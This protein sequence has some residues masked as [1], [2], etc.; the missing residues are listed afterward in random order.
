MGSIPPCWTEVKGRIRAQS[1][2]ATAPDR[3]GGVGSDEVPLV[4]GEEKSSRG[5]GRT[6]E[7]AVESKGR[8]PPA[9]V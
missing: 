7:Q 9:F 4:G 3:C 6:V 5:S 8:E 2:E 1:S